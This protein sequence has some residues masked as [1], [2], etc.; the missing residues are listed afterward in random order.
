ML[1]DTCLDQPRPGTD[2]WKKAV[3]QDDP[4]DWSKKNLAMHGSP[5]LHHVFY[6]QPLDSC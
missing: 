5:P 1:G 4:A 2:A 3:A 6:F